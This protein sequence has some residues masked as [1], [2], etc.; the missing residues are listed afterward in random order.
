VPS[1]YEISIV[2]KDG[3]VR[4]LEVFRK[5]VLWNGKTQFQVL[6]HDITGHKQAEEATQKS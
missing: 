3:E 6:Y 1:N 2:R 5:E 4:H